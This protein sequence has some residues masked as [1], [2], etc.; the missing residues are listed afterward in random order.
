MGTDSISL[1]SKIRLSGV[2]TQFLLL[3]KLQKA[4]ER[5]NSTPH[6]YCELD[7]P[8][9]ILCRMLY[10]KIPQLGCILI[11]L[12]DSSLWNGTNNR[13]SEEQRLLNE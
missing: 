5:M 7:C 1:F 11:D 6:P 3:R 12:T 4:K 10:R 2:T 13:F 9:L 8:W